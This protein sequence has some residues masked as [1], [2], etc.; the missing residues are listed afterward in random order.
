[1]D[2][3]SKVHLE[4]SDLPLQLALDLERYLSTQ[5]KDS[6]ITIHRSSHGIYGHLPAELQGKILAQNVESS[7]LLQRFNKPIKEYTASDF[8]ENECSKPISISE[9]ETE[10]LYLV[11]PTIITNVNA[12]NML[13]NH[14]HIS[15]GEYKIVNFGV[16]M[17]F[18][19]DDDDPDNVIIEYDS[20]Q[21]MD[22]ETFQKALENGTCILSPFDEYN[23]LKKRLSCINYDSNYANKFLVEW[24]NTVVPLNIADDIRVE[25]LKIIAMLEY[26]AINIMPYLDF[27]LIEDT[28]AINKMRD[29]H[30]MSGEYDTNSQSELKANV[31][32]IYELSSEVLRYYI[33]QLTGA[34]YDKINNQLIL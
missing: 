9:I 25:E 10:Q 8:F 31:I 23:I 5:Y 32:P 7:K 13:I 18:G 15:V 4:I 20:V 6:D 27:E 29:Y 19:V 30:G 11:M 14:I 24:Y 21:S 12:D 3:S 2:T 28:S 17:N 26:L 16:G 1:M 33:M 22:I 34:R